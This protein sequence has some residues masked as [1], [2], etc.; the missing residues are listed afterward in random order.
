MAPSRPVVMVFGYSMTDTVEAI[1]I[2]GA[3]NAPTGGAGAVRV[4]VAASGVTAAKR[5]FSTAA[6]RKVAAASA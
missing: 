2:A 5:G 6:N 3:M 4:S 1:A